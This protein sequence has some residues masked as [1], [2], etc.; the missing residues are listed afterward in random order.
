MLELKNISVQFG[1]IKAL[2]DVSFK[3][4]N[5]TLFS[6][7][8]PNVIQK[9]RSK[10]NKKFLNKILISGT[11]GHKAFYNKEEFKQID[12]Y[13]IGTNELFSWLKQIKGYR[14]INE[15]KKK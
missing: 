3:V 12:P 13:L 9:N 11:W 8:G 7:I 5:K 10:R 4:E 15:G 1:G 6:I 14:E 2:T